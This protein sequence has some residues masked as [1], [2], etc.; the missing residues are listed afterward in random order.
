MS[1][2]GSQGEGANRSGSQSAWVHRDAHEGVPKGVHIIAHNC[3]M[4]KLSDFTGLLHQNKLPSGV[5]RSVLFVWG[6]ES[7]IQP[8]A[9]DMSFAGSASLIGAN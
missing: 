4:A 7:T 6:I 1:Q 3:K 8:L 9:V 5:G 2:N